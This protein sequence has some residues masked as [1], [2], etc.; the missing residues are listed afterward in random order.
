MRSGRAP[1]FW[2][3]EASIASNLLLPVAALYGS[4]ARRNLESG[5]RAA[6]DV[7]VLCVGNFTAGGGG[8]TP[9]ALALAGAAAALGRKPGFV[10]RGHGRRRRETE[11]VDPARHGVADVG[12]EPLLLAA[13]APTAVGADRGAALS[14]LLRE[15]EVDFVIMDDGFQSQR[16]LIDHAVIALDARRG[17]GN[18]R[19]I[20]AGPLRAPLV[21]QVRRSG[22]LLV[23]GEGEREKEPLRA[24][25]R[26]GRPIFRA[27]LVSKSRH[28]LI[29]ERLL[30]FAGI[31]DP[32]KFYASLGELG[33]EV[34]QTRDFPD[35]HAF[36]DG[37]ARRLDRRC[38]KGRADPCHHPQGRGAPCHRQRSGAGIPAQLRGA[39]R[40][41]G[42]CRCLRCAADRRG[43]ARRLRRKALA[44]GHEEI[45]KRT[46]LRAA[47][48]LRQQAAGSRQPQAAPLA[49]NSRSRLKEAAASI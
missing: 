41:A 34:S 9:T 3:R 5:R 40:G 10:S 13:V 18:G 37:E 22:S 29:G 43:N 35:H 2:W 39:R 11:I 38:G 46:L 1:A 33:A 24:M 47:R 32:G 42:I 6:F 16:L 44:K 30:A 15:T 31:A 8:K 49:R 19:V 36:T 21:D 17:I 27:R 26:A 20:P 25:A 7:P 45:L 23:I 4:A 28:I 14:R 48:L 12:D